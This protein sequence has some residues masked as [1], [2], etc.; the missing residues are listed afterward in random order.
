MQYLN[1]GKKSAQV[2]FLSLLVNITIADRG[3]TAV[4]NISEYILFSYG[5]LFNESLSVIRN[6]KGEKSISSR[7][8]SCYFAFFH[9][10]SFLCREHVRHKDQTA[11]VYYFCVA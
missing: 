6:N 7:L 10:C 8:L 3:K 9:S 4:S 1:N 11:I 5:R 2:G